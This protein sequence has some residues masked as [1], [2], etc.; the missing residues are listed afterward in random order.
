VEEQQ[1]VWVAKKQLIC[2]F[3]QGAEVRCRGYS[4][5]L[6]RVITD[7]GADV[8]FGQISKKLQEH[9]GIEVPTSS[10]QA[11]TEKHAGHFLLGEQREN[12]WPERA[13]VKELIVESD[14]SM[15]P[16]VH[17]GGAQAE[18]MAADRRK[19]RP[20]EW[21]QARLS[22]VRVAGEGTPRFAGTMGTAEQA[23]AQM[24]DLALQSGLGTET[25]LHCLGDGAEWIYTQVKLQ[26]GEQADYLIDFFHLCEYLASTA[27]IC[28]GMDSAAWLEKQKVLMKGSQPEDVLDN[29]VSFLERDAPK[30]EPTPVQACY[31]Y[32]ENRPDQFNYRGAIEA[33]L[34]IGSGEIESA[35]RYVVQKRLKLA[36]AWW[37]FENAAKMLALQVARANDRWDEYWKNSG[38]KAA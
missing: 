12:Q 24:L 8:A 25:H 3:Q 21:K 6:Q 18:P 38:S 32:I 29:L 17:P 13:G 19:Q 31:R 9:Y 35:H 28:G 1:F 14:G 20:V 37:L 36:G 2:S 27:P 5:P 34:P 33:G 11:I 23:G 30:G 22:L 10:A 4:G 15:I 26:F 7:F 16:V